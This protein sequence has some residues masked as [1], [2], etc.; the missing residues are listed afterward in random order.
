M[1][2]C[3]SSEE[4]VVVQYTTLGNTA[5]GLTFGRDMASLDPQQ[6]ADENEGGGSEEFAEAQ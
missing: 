6:R 5:R 4:E 1:R 2:G 3:L